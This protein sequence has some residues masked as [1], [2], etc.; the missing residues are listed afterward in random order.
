MRAQ[1]LRHW[2]SRRP[3]LSRVCYAPTHPGWQ[4]TKPPSWLPLCRPSFCGVTPACVGT[5]DLAGSW[6][7]SIASDSQ[8]GRSPCP[9]SHHHCGVTL[10]ECTT[11]RLAH[12]PTHITY[13]VAADAEWSVRGRMRRWVSV[14]GE[15]EKGTR[16][17]RG[18][19]LLSVTEDSA[20]TC[21]RNQQWTVS[22]GST[23][24]TSCYKLPHA[25]AS[26][27]YTQTWQATGPATSPHRWCAAGRR[28]QSQSG[29]GCSYPAPD[30]ARMPRK[31]STRS[32]ASSCPAEA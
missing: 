11:P 10:C 32:A 21:V 1:C 22:V 26:G 7:L 14:S 5:I 24:M 30:Q 29:R 25:P 17:A 3:S 8:G 27:M 31:H 9:T 4:W 23:H 2:H 28:A 12:A 16:G 15:A 13:N 20:N 6:G 18:R 19:D